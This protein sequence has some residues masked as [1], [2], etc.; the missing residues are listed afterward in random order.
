[1]AAP[2]LGNCPKCRKLYLRIREICDDCYQK[3]DEDYLKVA[4]YLREYPGTTIQ[5]L[6]DETAVSIAQIRHFIMI[7]RII[8]GNFPNL[9]YPCETCGNMIKTGRTCS[10]CR[11]TIQQL[12][13]KIEQEDSSHDRDIAGGYIT[14][15]L[16]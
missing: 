15:Y 4:V 1:M 9:S 10:S 14:K 2:K 3:Q 8:M 12:T 7:G 11:D 5:V 16:K 13:A 6:S